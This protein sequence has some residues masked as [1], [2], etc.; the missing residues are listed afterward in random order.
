MKVYSDIPPPR[1]RRSRSFYEIPHLHACVPQEGDAE[2]P[3]GSFP[4]V[5]IDASEPRSDLEMSKLALAAGEVV[6][7]EDRAEVAVHSDDNDGFGPFDLA[8]ALV[9]EK[10]DWDSWR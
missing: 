2:Q 5:P 4:R 8:G 7:R 6:L 3:S 1:P 9:G 10:T